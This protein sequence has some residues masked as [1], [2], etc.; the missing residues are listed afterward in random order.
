MSK[1]E[2]EQKF[3]LDLRREDEIHEYLLARITVPGAAVLGIRQLYDDNGY[4]YRATV[5]GSETIYVR[6]SKRSIK[7][8]TKYSVSVE[9]DD[10]IMPAEFEDRW[11][12][13]AKRLQKTRFE[14]AGR[15]PDHKIMV[16][17]FFSR[18]HHERAYAIV[19]EAE[20]MLTADT[21]YLYLQFGLP[22]DLE[23]YILKT[24]DERDPGTKCF[25]SANMIDTPERIAAVLEAYSRLY[26]SV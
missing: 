17:F 23:K 6:E 12:R 2:F 25:K 5:R 20:T 10:E 18:K 14:L 8:G 13:A 9:D 11:F 26:E 7:V 24:V 16:D 22:I 3:V 15:Y 4:R 1:L 21:E 19:A